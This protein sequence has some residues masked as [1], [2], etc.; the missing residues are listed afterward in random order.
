M[1]GNRNDAESL[2]EWL[3]RREKLR[4]QGV[5]GNGCGTPLPIAVKLWPTPTVHGNH[6]RKGASA[7][8]GDGLATAAK[9]W[10]TPTARDWRSGKASAET[11]QRNARPL[12]EVV[13]NWPTPTASPSANR[14]T[15]RC[16][17]HDKGHGKVLAG[18]VGGSL[19]PEFV[20]A[21][22]GLP[23]GWTKVGPLAPA[24]RRKSGKRRAK[25]RRAKT[26]GRG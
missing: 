26:A 25:P 11:M 23:P 13:A 5:N 14:N 6:N 8:S 15:K 22:M 20:E 9:D 17:S 24:K 1:A 10:P 7:E 21:L 2:T 19:N 18:E 16:P 3:S 12:N 4:A